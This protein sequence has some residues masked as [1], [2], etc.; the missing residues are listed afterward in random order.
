MDWFHK[1][2]L[3]LKTDP[4]FYYR[5]SIGRFLRNIAMALPPACEAAEKVIRSHWMHFSQTFPPSGDLKG[6]TSPTLFRL[7]DFF[8]RSFEVGL[9]AV[10]LLAVKVEHSSP[11][12]NAMEHETN[13][14]SRTP[15]DLENFF[16]EEME[17]E[18]FSVA[19][20]LLYSS[21]VG[22]SVSVI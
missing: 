13:E 14:W 4:D 10:L 8:M 15:I 3:M 2:W 9:N 18:P 19:S 20:P 7:L 21:R 22:R 5:M 11:R 6:I 16:S 17:I 1:L 12:R